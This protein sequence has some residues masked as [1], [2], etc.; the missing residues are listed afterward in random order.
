MG[1]SKESD[2]IIENMENQYT[3]ETWEN[4]VVYHFD[5]FFDEFKDKSFKKRTDY[6][7]NFLPKYNQVFY[8]F[9]DHNEIVY[10]HEMDM[11]S[12]N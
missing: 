8:H 5:H 12:V 7:T 3:N 6:I 11:S 2:V 9:T 4:T 10:N 1:E